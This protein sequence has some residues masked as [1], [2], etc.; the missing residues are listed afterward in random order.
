VY[1]DGRLL[2]TLRGN[3]I[4]AEFLVI[5]NDYVASHYGAAEPVGQQGPM[6]SLL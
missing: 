6:G 5:L 4:V 1:V 2:V 3:N